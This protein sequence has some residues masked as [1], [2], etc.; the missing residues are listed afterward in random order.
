MND[1]KS[2]KEQYNKSYYSQHKEEWYEKIECD[3]CKGLYCRASK[4]NHFKSKKHIYAE[5]DKQLQDLTQKINDI[6][7][8]LKIGNLI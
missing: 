8:T 3:I 1:L 7:T 2:K 6:K 5:K 4:Y